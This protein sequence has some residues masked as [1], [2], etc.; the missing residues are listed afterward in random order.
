M[1]VLFVVFEMNICLSS[2][3][4]C[5]ISTST[6]NVYTC[7][8]YE[9]WSRGLCNNMFIIKPNNQFLLNNSTIQMSTNQAQ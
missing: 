4:I 9:T 1:Y 2:Y 7:K 3:S 5:Q 8:L 6:I